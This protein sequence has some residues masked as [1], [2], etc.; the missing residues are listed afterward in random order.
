VADA[1]TWSFANLRKFVSSQQLKSDMFVVYL[2]LGGRDASVGGIITPDGFHVFSIYDFMIIVLIGNK[3][4]K[5]VQNLWKDIC[6]QNSQFM[7]VQGTLG[8]AVP[9][10][11]MPK[12]PPTAGMS[13][14]GL[15]GVLDALGY[16]VSEACRKTVED[17]FA[18]YMAGDRSMIVEVNLNEKE[19]PQI[20]RFSYNFQPPTASSNVPVTSI[21]I[22]DAGAG[23]SESEASSDGS[24]EYDFSSTEDHIV[25][26]MPERKKTKHHGTHVGA[27][28][29]A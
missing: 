29:E 1:M 25:K 21:V 20:P 9:S 23:A 24:I 19:H 13:V 22:E 6:R 15:K 10:T 14:M 11:K 4:R 27:G 28:A 12:T 26:S 5:D 7:E 8:L 17:I 2:L 3:S 16:R 18:R